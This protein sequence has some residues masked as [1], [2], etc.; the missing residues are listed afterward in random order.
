MQS[1]KPSDAHSKYCVSPNIAANDWQLFG[2]RIAPDIAVK[3]AWSPNYEYRAPFPSRC[4]GVCQMSD[5]HVR[6]CILGT[7]EATR[8]DSNSNRMSGFEFY[9]K[10]TCL[11]EILES[12]TRAVC[13]H[14]TNYA[15]SLFNKNINLC[16]VCSWDMCLQLHFTCSSTAVARA[17]TQLSHD[18][19]HWTL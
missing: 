5:S 8:F 19:R 17:Q 2:A 16:A 14:T 11:F 4:F 12:A 10:V 1:T 7:C 13:R 15:H 18:N 3:S 6:R 9:S